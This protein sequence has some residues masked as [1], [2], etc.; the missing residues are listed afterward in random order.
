V[1]VLDDADP[2]AGSRNASAIVHVH[3]YDSPIFADLWP[4]DW[5]REE[6]ERSLGW[7]VETCGAR[8]SVETFWNLD[9]RDLGQRTSRERPPLYL[10]TNG[11]LLDLVAAERRRVSALWRDGAEWIAETWEGP[12]RG[13][14]VLVAAG[15]RTDEVLASAGLGTLGVRRLFGRGLLVEGR[16]VVALPAMVM[17]GPYRK[18]AIRDWAPGVVRVGDSAERTPREGHA[19][20]L[21]KLAEAIVPGGREVGWMAGY[22]PVLDRFTVA[23]LADGLAV[24]TGGHRMALGLAGLVARRAVSM[25][26]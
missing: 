8:P 18:Y 25:L 24:A 6:L 14:R 3:T 16:A 9:R 7:L 22:R 2:L 21:R 12:V 4:R 19:A 5:S 10:P 26:S 15:Y 17:G 23:K 13:R 20:F 11:A 1:R